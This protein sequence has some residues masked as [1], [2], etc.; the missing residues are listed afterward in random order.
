LLVTIAPEPR[1]VATVSAAIA[2]LEAVSS[3]PATTARPAIP[4]AATTV[5]R[6]TA[7]LGEGEQCQ[8]PGALD[9]C[10]QRALVLGAGAGLAAWLDHP[11][12]GDEPAHPRHVLVVDM[13]DAIDAEAADLAARERAATATTPTKPA[14]GTRA[15]VAA[16]LFIS[17][18]SHSTLTLQMFAM[19]RPVNR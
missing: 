14:R 5:A 11:T 18:F 9:R 17:L 8:V 15:A 10:R 1:P 4:I 19:Y 2:T 13:L 3:E 7:A 16:R 6:L 12:V